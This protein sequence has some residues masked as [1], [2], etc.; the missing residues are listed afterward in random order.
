[1]QMEE[2][3]RTYETQRSLLNSQMAAARAKMGKEAF[4]TVLGKQPSAIEKLLSPTETSRHFVAINA[5]DSQQRV[6][7]KSESASHNQIPAID[8]SA[9]R[10]LSENMRLIRARHRHSPI[11]TNFGF[12][13]VYLLINLGRSETF[14]D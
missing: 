12:I 2:K 1:M 10:E 6:K 13:V 5:N 9:M 4:F 14:I 11:A 3:R 7:T 8:E